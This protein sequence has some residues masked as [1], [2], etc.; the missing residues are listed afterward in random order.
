[1]H[2]ALP[3]SVLM[4][5]YLGGAFAAVEPDATAIAYRDA[6]A[7]VMSAAFTAPNVP[8][9]ERER[10]DAAWA[11][12]SAL[13]VGVYGNFTNSTDPAVVQRM[14]PADTRARLAAVKREWDPQ[15]LFRRNHNVPPG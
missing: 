9:A 13:T 11:P 4:I 14:Y 2:G 12:T 15:N 5:R 8:A 1:M 6:E 7:F 10:F 3:G